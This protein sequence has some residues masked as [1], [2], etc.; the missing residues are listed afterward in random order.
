MN[1]KKIIR[2]VS[3]VPL[4]LIC[5]LLAAFAGY[6]IYSTDWASLRAPTQLSTKQLSVSKDELTVVLLGT[7]CP[8]L[9]AKRSR[10]AQAVLA[11]NKIFLVDCGGGTVQRLVQAGIEPQRVSGVFFTHHHSDHNSGFIDFFVS[12]WIGGSEER[13]ESLKIYGPPGAKE[14]IGKMRDALNYDV[15]VRLMHQKPSTEGL[16][17]VYT[18]MMEGVIYDDDQ[19]KVSVFPVD[20]RPVN[21]AVGFMFEYKGKSVVFSGD[22]RP[23]Q[24]VVKYGQNAGLL[25]HE[26]YSGNLMEKARRMYPERERLINAV[27]N[28]RSST[29]EVAKMA[30]EA[31]VKHLVLTHLIPPPSETWYFERAFIKGMRDIYDGKITVGRDLMAITVK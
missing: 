21:E 16:N 1:M 8:I 30:G 31:K 15:D 19:I 20:H 29:L 5:A 10:P 28:Y 26:A 7:G 9:N 11:A 22:T 18:E 13:K 3:I 23:C 27:M 4:G 14:I 2:V 24:N 25:V 17:I 6:G 12:S